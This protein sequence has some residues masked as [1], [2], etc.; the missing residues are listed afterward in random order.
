MKIVPYGMAGTAEARLRMSTRV[1][2]VIGQIGV[3]GCEKQLLE[4]VRRADR[5]RCQYGLCYYSPDTDN[6]IRQFTEAG[7]QLYY[8]DKFGPSATTWKF[9]RSLRGTIRQFNP[10]ILHTWLYSA[11]FWGRLAGRSLGY[12]RLIASERS[13]MTSYPLA[14]RVAE[15]LLRCTYWTANSRASAQRVRGFLGV[16]DQRMKVLYN[17]VDPPNRNVQ[18]DRAE[19]RRELGLGPEQKLVLMVGRL[20]EAKDHP[21]LFRAAQR[22]LAIDPPVTFLCAGHGELEA[23]LRRELAERKLTDRVRLLGLRRDVP[24]LLSAADVFCL[25]SRFEGF[26]NAVAEA[27]AAGLPV[28]CTRFEGVEEVVQD[29]RTGLLVGVGDDEALARRVGELLAE[30]GARERLGQAAR[31]WVRQNLSWDRLLGQMDELYRQVLE[32]G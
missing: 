17:A 25:T 24:R 8:V 14:A 30:P 23:A 1:L 4:L 6:L 2:H 26:P 5:A 7:V 13:F 27:M 31:E 19:V 21:T 11:N 9:F 29:G 22:V 32:T 28:V 15:R 12:R 18:A 10:D 20:T 3:G 16:R